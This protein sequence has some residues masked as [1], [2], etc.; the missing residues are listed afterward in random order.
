MFAINVKIPNHPIS[1]SFETGN[2]VT[3]N[4]IHLDHDSYNYNHC[5]GIVIVRYKAK[6]VLLAVRVISCCVEHIAQW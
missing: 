6:D 3:G 4:I 1:C 5:N 2:S